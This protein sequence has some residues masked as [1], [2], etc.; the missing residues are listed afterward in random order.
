MIATSAPDK[1][2]EARK[3][4]SIRQA[5]RDAEAAWLGRFPWLAKTDLIG[6]LLF[7]AAAAG[8]IFTGLLYWQGWI[9]W[10]GCVLINAFLASVLHEIEHDLI[11]FLY[12]RDRPWAHNFM[13]FV[14]WA[15]RGNI[16]HG[17][18]RRAIHYLHHRSSGSAEDVEERLL[19]LGRPWGWRRL[20]ITLDGA[21]AYYL[22]APELER[23]I[24]EFKRSDLFYASLP[25]YPLFVLSAAGWLTLTTVSFA[26]SRLGPAPLPEP[27]TTANAVFGV[28]CVTWVL[29]N[30]LRQASLQLVSSNVHYYGDVEHLN[31]QTQVLKPIWMLPFQLFCFNFGAT[32]ILHHY[33]VRQPFY[34]RQLAAPR[35]YPTL[36][37]CGVRFDDVGTFFRGNRYRID[38]SAAS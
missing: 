17:W 19:G 34:L 30:Y 15:L 33:V 6:T 4:Q 18:F 14:V 8:M 29:P 7:T 25:F 20:L 26:F 3:A 11:H 24:P 21:A 2:K 13:L 23:E 31:Q 38:R 35:V 10:W 36:R 16:V 22:A 5:I 27:L 32:H 37:R 12:F 28:L 9:P 1:T